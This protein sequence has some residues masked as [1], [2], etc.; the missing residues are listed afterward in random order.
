MIWLSGYLTLLFELLNFFERLYEIAMV[1]F[2]SQ[3]RLFEIDIRYRI[4]EER[5]M[6]DVVISYEKDRLLYN[7]NGK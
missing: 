4:H 1:M 2:A 7:I 3:T 6:S 5:R